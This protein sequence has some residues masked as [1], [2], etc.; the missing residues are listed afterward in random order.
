MNNKK[1]IIKISFISLFI[2]GLCLVY[3]FAYKKT[4]QSF[5]NMKSLANQIASETLTQEAILSVDR[6]I[7]DTEGLR[8]ELVTHFINRDGIVPFFDQVEQE[9]IASD[10][11]IEIT[12]VTEP[13]EPG[14]PLLFTVKTS[15]TFANNYRFLRIMENMPFEIGVGKMEM[16]YS[17]G[18][19]VWNMVVDFKLITF[20]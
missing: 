16:T 11:K 18:T 8:S 12:S 7:K 15:G 17:P 14:A 13:K 2:I 10:V 19:N 5:D 1:Y 20:I 9:G 3:Y 6:N 4:S